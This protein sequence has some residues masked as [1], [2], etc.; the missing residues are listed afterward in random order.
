[1]NK[2]RHQRFGDCARCFGSLYWFFFFAF[3]H[4][5][6]AARRADSLGSFAPPPLPRATLQD[7]ALAGSLQA[8]RV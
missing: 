7:R 2:V 8:T 4:L 3:A 1:M 5:A 6:W